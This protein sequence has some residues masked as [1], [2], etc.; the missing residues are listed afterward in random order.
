MFCARKNGWSPLGGRCTNQNGRGF[1][2]CVMVERRGRSITTLLSVTGAETRKPVTG[3]Q[4]SSSL[5]RIA[6][7]D[8]NHFIA[9]GNSFLLSRVLRACGTLEIFYYTNTDHAV[10]ILSIADNDPVFC[11]FIRLRRPEC[12]KPT[13]TERRFAMTHMH[14]RSNFYLREE[15]VQSKC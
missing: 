3:G 11:C 8:G 13:L 1:L 15:V 4:D 6:W 2:C 10:F 9:I 7:S 14:H 12:D 5:T